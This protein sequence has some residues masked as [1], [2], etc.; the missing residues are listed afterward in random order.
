MISSKQTLMTFGIILFA[1][2]VGVAWGM[3]IGAFS[4]SEV[5]TP[6][7][8]TLISPTSGAPEV[9]PTSILR[10][11]LAVPSSTTPSPLPAATQT[12][13][14]TP[15]REA[16]SSPSSTPTQTPASRS[17]TATPAVT[18]SPTLTFIRYIV[19]EGDTL[20]T[21]AARYGTSVEALREANGL[22]SDFLR[23]GDELRIPVTEANTFLLTATPTRPAPV[24][25][26]A[27]Q[28]PPPVGTATTAYAAPE[29]VAPEDGTSTSVP[30]TLRWSWNGTLGP[31]EYFDVRLW[32]AGQPHYGIAWTK[33]PEFVL[34]DTSRQGTYFWSVAVV[35]GQNG[36]WVADL[37]P[38]APARQLTLSAPAPADGGARN[39]E[40]TRPQPTPT[41]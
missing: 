41:R 20:S 39:G 17:F 19:E 40:G 24:T 8:S 6:A 25:P 9:V 2:L 11:A 36:K 34:N 33:A 4:S 15:T 23:I 29:L 28:P 13:T 3:A 38:E 1:V 12:Q 7:N 10:G 21:I 18:P 27:P 16:A 31:D 14:Q 22:T 26:V 30:V 5:A 32:Q 35:R 37:S